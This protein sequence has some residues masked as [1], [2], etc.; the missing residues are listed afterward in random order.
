MYPAVI[1]GLI[2]QNDD[3]R[4]ENKVAHRTAADRD[5][6]LAALEAMNDAF[7]GCV[8]KSKGCAP[9][10]ARAAINKSKGV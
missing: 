8:C 4:A 1:Q 2:R 7:G 9:C 5:R 3:L 10:I 6:L